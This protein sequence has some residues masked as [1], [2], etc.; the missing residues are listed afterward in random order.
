M[1][2][3]D[4]E[5]TAQ[6]VTV[7]IPTLSEAAMSGQTVFE[8]NCAQCHGVNG[9]GT[10]QGLPLIHPI[11]N[12]GHHADVAFLLAVRRGVPQHHWQF[13]AMPPQPQIT[14]DDVAL[15]VQFVREVQKA[16]GIAFEEHTM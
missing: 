10:D 14:E 6:T 1:V 9:A 11:Y 4:E 5:P 16:N 8:E 7:V 2:R 3:I 12:P 15:L 13:G